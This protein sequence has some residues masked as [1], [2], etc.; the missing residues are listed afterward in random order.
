MRCPLCGGNNDRV[1]ESRSNSAG[2]SIRRR[3]ECLACGYRFTS[4]EQIVEKQ[5]MVIKRDGRREPFDPLKLERGIQ[6]ALEKRPISQKSI[7]GMVHEI[8]DEISLREAGSREVGTA[9]IGELVL[10]KLYELDRVAYIRFASV[11]KMFE[12]IESFKEEIDQLFQKHG[13][14]EEHN[15]S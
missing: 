7:E 6:T 2:T 14:R 4:Y 9:S 1:L 10:A 12:D 13:N 5:L 8:E 11:Y 15:E 3:R